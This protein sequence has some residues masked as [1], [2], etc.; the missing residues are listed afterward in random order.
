MLK[1]S[2]A[3]LIRITKNFIEYVLQGIPQDIKFENS[4]LELFI[5][6]IVYINLRESHSS[7][8]ALNP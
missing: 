7:H 3:N 8:M 5:T 2:V 1:K 6:K 4:I